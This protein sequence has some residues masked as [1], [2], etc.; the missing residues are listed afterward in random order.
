ML[1][2]GAA[3]VLS[4]GSES[5]SDA[6]MSDVPQLEKV[7]K[8]LGSTK[9]VPKHAVIGARMSSKSAAPAPA[10]AAKAA[11]KAAAGKAG[12]SPG[13]SCKHK[14]KQV[15]LKRAHKGRPSKPLSS[16]SAEVAAAPQEPRSLLD[17]A[18]SKPPRSPRSVGQASVTLVIVH[19]LQ[20]QIHKTRASN[21]ISFLQDTAVHDENQRGVW[22][23][24]ASAIASRGTGIHAKWR[25]RQCQDC[26]SHQ[27]SKVW[28]AVQPCRQIW[29]QQGVL[30]CSDPTRVNSVVC[31]IMHV[32][33][34]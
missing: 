9:Y 18:S 8:Q 17:S 3:L 34:R 23:A 4:S 7:R 25:Q 11:R 20:T 29:Q 14:A 1:Q 16:L 31:I 33:V 5:D 27:H 24:A 21:C 26:A 32:A 30:P 6:W 19:S 13:G 10:A 28:Q 2:G 15:A 22:L 12:G